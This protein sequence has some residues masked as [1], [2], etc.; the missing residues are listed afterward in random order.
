[1]GGTPIIE[2][3]RL[4]ERGDFSQDGVH[5]AALPFVANQLHRFVD[6]SMRWR[7]HFQNFVGTESKRPA[8]SAGGI[9]N[10][11]IEKWSELS[12]EPELPATGSKRQLGEKAC[13]LAG[14]GI[15]PDRGVD[16]SI[17][18]RSV[19]VDAKEKV[20]REASDLNLFGHTKKAGL[21]ETGSP[22]LY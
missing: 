15:A 1:M 19:A 10:G 9:F 11:A 16:E 5:K 22:Y 20:M 4:I 6:S 8:D 2:L 13:I 7:A 12:V 17:G 21:N 18:I 14:Q 3:H